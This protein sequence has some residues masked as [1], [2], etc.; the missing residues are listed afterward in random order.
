MFPN[1]YVNTCFQLHR[2]K[3]QTLLNFV[4]YKGLLEKSAFKKIATQAFEAGDFLN[5]FLRFSGFW[6]SF[7]YN[8]FSYEKNVYKK[9]Y[10]TRLWGENLSFGFISSRIGT[11]TCKVLS[12]WDVLKSLSEKL[13]PGLCIQN[14]WQRVFNI[15][16]KK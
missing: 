8:N 1:I 14:L 9:R 3:C 11:W 7:S 15:L 4:T 5:I 6:G 16:D 12:G 13:W 2:K 10:K